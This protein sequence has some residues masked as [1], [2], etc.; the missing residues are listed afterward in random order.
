MEK[1]RNKVSLS[2][3]HQVSR[4]MLK[5][6]KRLWSNPSL[7]SQRNKKG[8]REEKI[9]KKNATRSEGQR[10]AEKDERKKR[11]AEARDVVCSVKKKRKNKS[12]LEGS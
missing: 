2:L 6:C 8:E 5:N 11:Q 4:A 7:T 12:R 3:S 1:Q 10:L 9:K